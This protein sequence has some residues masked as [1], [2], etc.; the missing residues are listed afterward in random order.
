[1]DTITHSVG[2]P[3][4]GLLITIGIVFIILI[5]L[6]IVISKSEYRCNRKSV[7]RK[8]VCVYGKFDN[9]SDFVLEP[10]TGKEKE[11]KPFWIQEVAE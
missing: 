2:I 7:K 11:L 10:A 5:I 8:V 4:E 6:L 1:M 3:L 9:K